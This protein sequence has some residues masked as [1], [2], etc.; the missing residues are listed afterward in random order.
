MIRA[1]VQAYLDGEREID[2]V[3]QK[4]DAHV[5]SEHA[6]IDLLGRNV[7]A[8]DGTWCDSADPHRNEEGRPRRK[9]RRATK[10]R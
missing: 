2:K 6:A 9:M 10:I 5:G 7:L 3:K 1:N 8:L 4:G